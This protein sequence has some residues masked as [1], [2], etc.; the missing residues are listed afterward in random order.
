MYVRD[1]FLKYLHKVRTEKQQASVEGLKAFVEAKYGN[2]LV[3]EPLP[4]KDYYWRP[5]VADYAV[6][7][8]VSEMSANGSKVFAPP[9]PLEDYQYPDLNKEPFRN[10]S[11]LE[12]LMHTNAFS[13]DLGYASYESF[14][15]KLSGVFETGRG[16][17][18]NFG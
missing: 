17:S 12:L 5:Y 6:F 16:K 10:G 14:W 13:L 3:P 18:L 9:R 1:T 8:P 11:Q 15:R 4:T 7:F 2:T